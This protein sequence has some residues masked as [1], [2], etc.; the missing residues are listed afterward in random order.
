MADHSESELR[1]EEQVVVTIRQGGSAVVLAREFE[2]AVRPEPIRRVLP[3]ED[4]IAPSTPAAAHGLHQPL[5]EIERERPIALL[6]AVR[7][8]HVVRDRPR[9]LGHDRERGR[10]RTESEAG[11]QPVP[12]RVLRRGRA[13][14]MRPSA[15]DVIGAT[16]GRRSKLAV[17]RRGWVAGGV[18]GECFEAGERRSGGDPWRRRRGVMGDSPAAR[19][20]ANGGFE[21][22]WDSCAAPPSGQHRHLDRVR[23]VRGRCAH[24]PGGGEERLQRGEFPSSR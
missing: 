10:A 20:S 6:V 7:A 24:A 5:A 23:Q 21:T 1:V 9:G 8:G 12:G 11:F 3:V 19:L 14:P 16:A 15:P 4:G 2:A 17:R 18:A 22:P 13:L